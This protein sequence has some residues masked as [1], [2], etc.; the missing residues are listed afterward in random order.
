MTNTITEAASQPVLVSSRP[1]HAPG[2][3][4]RYTLPVGYL[5]D[6]NA[7]LVVS[8]HSEQ[9]RWWR[10]LRGGAPVVLHLRGRRVA[11]HAEVI[12]SPLSVASE[13]ERLVDLLGPKEASARLYMDLENTSQLSREQLAGALKGVVLVR[14]TPEHRDGGQL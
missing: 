12:E 10:N 13:I 2:W 8:Q 14:F 11:A 7:L 4:A 5:P 1:V 3:Y 9:K 6:G